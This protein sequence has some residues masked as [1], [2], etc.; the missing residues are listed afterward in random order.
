MAVTTRLGPAP[1]K[2]F[3]WTYTKLKN[4][5]ACPKKHYEVDVLKNFQEDSEQLTWGNSV[6]DALAKRVGEK[7]T[8]LPKGM[9]SYEPWAEKLVTTPGNIFV[10]NKMGLTREFAPAGFFD[11][12][13]WLRAIVDV[14][15]IHGDVAL[16]IDWKTGKIKEDLVQLAL[17]AACVFA[18]YPEIKKIRARYV[19][20]QENAQT[21]E[22]FT[23]ED[24]P[25]LWKG[26]WPRV[27]ALEHAHNT[28]TYQAK[29]SGL[30]R[31]W[32]PVRDCPHYGG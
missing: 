23:P 18:K 3:T 15:K 8:P 26:L 30:C 5:E 25:G 27:Q 17:S 19:W 12:D 7:R 31:N 2:A 6:H 21:D 32:C 10:E 4:F 11:R 28:T 1:P 24:M 13:V 9:T 16:L 29:P 22:D 20:L 14:I